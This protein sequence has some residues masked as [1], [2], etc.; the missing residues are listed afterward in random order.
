VIVDLLL[1]AAVAFGVVTLAAIGFVPLLLPWPQRAR[2]TVAAQAMGDSGSALAAF[3]TLALREVVLSSVH[4]PDD[5]PVLTL[6]EAGRGDR[7]LRILHATSAIPAE[8]MVMLFEWSALRTP[9]LLYVDDSGIASLTGPAATVTGLRGI[10][11]ER[12]DAPSWP[13][14]PEGPR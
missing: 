3:P 6:N 8:V 9:M 7:D 12:G 13:P 10:A 2:W 14:V 1:V 5:G 4:D 11:T